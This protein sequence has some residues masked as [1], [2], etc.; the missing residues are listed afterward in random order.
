MQNTVAPEIYC[1]WAALHGIAA[2]LQR[3]VW[4]PYRDRELYPNL[5]M[6]LAGPPRIGKS[7]AADML[8]D[9]MNEVPDIVIGPASM[10][11][12]KLYVLMEDSRLT[13]NDV[14]GQPPGPYMH[15]S[16]N[17][18]HSE[19]GVLIKKG[20]PEITKVMCQLFDCGKIFVHSIKHGA[21]SKIEHVWL[22]MMGA[23]TLR[24]LRDMLPEHAFE[25]GFAARLILVYAD[26]KRHTDKKPA[27]GKKR[28]QLT[29]RNKLLSGLVLD[30]RRINKIAGPYEMEDEAYDRF[31]EW[32]DENGN[33]GAPKPP[34]M[35]LAP[36]CATRD[37]H[38]LKM[39]M[40][41]AASK[42]DERVI[43]LEDYKEALDLM[44]NTEDVM[45]LALGHIGSNI[46]KLAADRALC[47]MMRYQPSTS[48]PLCVRWLIS[49]WYR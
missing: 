43:L 28:H 2:A 34:S 45:H 7:T 4:L 47:C 10:T 33:N 40:I 21:P 12:E 38:C 19:L 14:P 42:R 46:Q 11:K 29:V 36:Y 35:Y 32:W 1:K 39:C 18:S 48:T 31:C 27:I 22:N 25:D 16:Y 41:V 15:C 23:A 20:D 24:G 30:L 26:T 5:Y 3:K 9:I 37:I 8:I 44:E 49:K 6:V 17:I 13:H